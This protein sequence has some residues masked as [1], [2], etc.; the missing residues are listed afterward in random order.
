[1]IVAYYTLAT[2]EIVMISDLLDEDEVVANR[3]P[4]CGYV[5]ADDDTDYRSHYVDPDT[6]A[7]TDRPR[8]PVMASGIYD[9]SVLA[10]GARLVVTDEVGVSTELPAQADMLELVDAGTWRVRSVSPFPWVDFEAEVIVP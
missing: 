8:V 10:E 3:P 9:L 1:M 7:L 6:L 5:P 2:G 4:T